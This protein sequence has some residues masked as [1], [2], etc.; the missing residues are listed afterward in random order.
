MSK[1][2]VRFHGVAA[3]NFSR[4]TSLDN[5]RKFN[6]SSRNTSHLL[7][8]HHHSHRRHYYCHCCKRVHCTVQRCSPPEIVCCPF[9]NYL[10][11][12]FITMRRKYK[13]IHKSTVKKGIKMSEITIIAKHNNWEKIH[14]KKMLQ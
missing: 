6:R 7:L 12:S 4:S 10:C 1:K 5:Y 9:G 13:S 11:F 3:T 2:Q 14:A 8:C